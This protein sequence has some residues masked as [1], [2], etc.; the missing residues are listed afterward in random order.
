[1]E[2]AQS[3]SNWTLFCPSDVP[4]LSEFSGEAFAREYERLEQLGLGRETIRARTLWREILEC[5]IQTGGPFILFK[6]AINSEYS[7]NS[8][9]SAI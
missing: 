3:N 8:R 4:G 5:A 2:R 6:D 9:V 7:R 1:M